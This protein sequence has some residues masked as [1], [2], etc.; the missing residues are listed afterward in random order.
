MPMRVNVTTLRHPAQSNQRHP[1]KDAQQISQQRHRWGKWRAQHRVRGVGGS[2]VDAADAAAA[3]GAVAGS[4]L[5]GA[6]A[7][8]AA[9][10][11]FLVSA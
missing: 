6:G 4:Y 3:V 7:A 2:G 1:F 11:D 9:I 8:V 5:V 10:S